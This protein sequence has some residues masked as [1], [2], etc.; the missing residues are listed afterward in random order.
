MKVHDYADSVGKTTE[1]TVT[2][3]ASGSR[4]LPRR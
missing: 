3:A 2:N 1:V 4:S